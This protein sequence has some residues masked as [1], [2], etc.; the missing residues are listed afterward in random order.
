MCWNHVKENIY[1]FVAFQLFYAAFTTI[2]W[3]LCNSPIEH[4]AISLLLLLVILLLLK[5]GLVCFQVVR[6]SLQGC[7]ANVSI[8]T[9]AG[10]NEI[11]TPLDW[12]TATTFSGATDPS[13]GCPLLASSQKARSAVYF[14]GT[15]N[16]T[17]HYMYVNQWRSIGLLV[18]NT[19]RFFE[20]DTGGSE[21]RGGHAP[22]RPKMPRAVAPLSIA[23]CLRH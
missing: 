3:N 16:S 17:T 8:L 22:L 6:Q 15:G 1:I 14:L 23:V 21:G 7:I 5:F 9:H 12:T 18:S 11:W 20:R 4:Q 13:G 19:G 10:P 2:T